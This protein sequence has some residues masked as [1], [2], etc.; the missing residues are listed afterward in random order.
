MPEIFIDKDLCK[1]CNI[2][3]DI[4]PTTVFEKNEDDVPDIKRKEDCIICLNCI[5][6]CPAEA[7]DFNETVEVKVYYW[8]TNAIKMIERMR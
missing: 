7:I 6:R 4:C 8:D 5:D 2:C 1:K 3:V